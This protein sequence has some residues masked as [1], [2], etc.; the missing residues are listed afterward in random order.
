MYHE[1]LNACVRFAVNI[2]PQMSV[3]PFRLCIGFML[4]SNRQN[5]FAFIVL[6]KII[7]F[8]F[9]PLLAGTIELV[10][11]SVMRRGHSSNR[12]MYVISR[13]RNKFGVQSF[14]RSVVSRWNNLPEHIE[15]SNTLSGF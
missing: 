14:S 10:P 13:V 4:A 12:N 3:A 2:P 6:L 8:E 15:S 9:P 5:Y 11:G 1:A 7:R